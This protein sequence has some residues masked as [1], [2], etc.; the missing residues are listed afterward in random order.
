MAEPRPRV[1]GFLV[2]QL[3]GGYREI[4]AIA[5]ADARS[6]VVDASSLNIRVRAI[7]ASGESEPAAAIINPTRQRA[8]RR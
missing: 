2:E 8:A 1:D 7:N 5:S 3:F 6:I 4:F